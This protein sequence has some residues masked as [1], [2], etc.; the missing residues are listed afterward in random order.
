ME[1]E[2][3]ESKKELFYRKNTRE[4]TRILELERNTYEGSWVSL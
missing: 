1:G 3:G 2:E 4:V